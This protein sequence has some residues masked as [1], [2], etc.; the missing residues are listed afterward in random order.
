MGQAIPSSL[1]LALPSAGLRT[2]RVRALAA[3]SSCTGASAHTGLQPSKG[4]PGALLWPS[5]RAEHGGQGPPEWEAKE[6]E[7]RSRPPCP[8]AASTPST[9]ALPSVM[10]SVFAFSKPGA[11]FLHVGAG[12]LPG[13]PCQQLA[14]QGGGQREW[15]STRSG[16]FAKNM[17]T[18]KWQK[19]EALGQQCVHCGWHFGL[20]PACSSKPLWPLPWGSGLF[21]VF[22]SAAH[23]F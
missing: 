4:E 9:G 23:K 3:G 21:G 6:R 12:S 20:G 13:Q 5:P 18:P 16:H 11:E 22:Q 19:Q 10:L 8:H 14:Q 15:T 2:R 17:T 7:G 1:S